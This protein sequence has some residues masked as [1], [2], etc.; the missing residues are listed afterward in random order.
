MNKAYHNVTRKEVGKVATKC[1]RS[2]EDAF[3]MWTLERLM[4][5]CVLEEYQ[6]TKMT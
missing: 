2:G 3:G 6:Y 1:L 5:G 4:F